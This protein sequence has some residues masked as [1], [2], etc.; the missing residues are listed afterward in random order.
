MPLIP[1][2]WTLTGAGAA[3]SLSKGSQ[4]ITELI[5]LGLVVFAGTK[6]VQEGRK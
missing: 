1:I 6:L 2:F 5:V 3:W 4:K